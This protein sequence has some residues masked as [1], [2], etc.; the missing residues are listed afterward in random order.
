MSNVKE[1]LKNEQWIIAILVGVIILA[2]INSTAFFSTLEGWGLL[3]IG[4]VGSYY[5]MT[6]GIKLTTK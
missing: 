6:S 2:L 1:F 5:V 3:I 4:V